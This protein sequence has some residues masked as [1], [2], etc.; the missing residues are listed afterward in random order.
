LK[1]KVIGL[2]SR[3]NLDFTNGL[4]LYDQVLEYSTF[5]GEQIMWGTR[6]ERWIYVDV[7][8]SEDINSK[9]HAHF[10]SPYTPIL[11]AG[12]TLGMTTLSPSDSSA[13]W[14]ENTFEASSTADASLFWPKMENFF[15]PEWLDIRRQELSLREIVSRQATAWENLMRDGAGWVKMERVYG[16]ESVREAYEKIAQGGLGPQKGLVWSLWGEHE[17]VK[18]RL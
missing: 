18:A 14:S 17:Q 5:A 3:G 8:G 12:V 15:M 7:S 13:K 2:T 11:A 16:E 10:G 6:E 9:V 4:G 1:V